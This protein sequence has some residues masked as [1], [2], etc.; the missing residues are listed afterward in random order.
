MTVGAYHRGS[1][2]GNWSRRYAGICKLHERITGHL[3]IEASRDGHFANQSL[4]CRKRTSL[5]SGYTASLITDSH[6][7]FYLKMDTQA[8]LKC[9]V[10]KFDIELIDVIKSYPGSLQPAVQELSLQ[11]EKGSIIT[12]LGPSGCGKTTTLSKKT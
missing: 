8:V 4:D 3:T 1:S 5:L 10:I 12:L 11:V 9:G 6:F 2:T 7:D